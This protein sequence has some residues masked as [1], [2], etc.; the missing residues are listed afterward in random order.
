MG[1]A[2]ESLVASF[3]SFDLKDF[4]FEECGVILPRCNAY[5]S[6]KSGLM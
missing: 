6:H 5:V 3:E 1:L 2:E 4:S